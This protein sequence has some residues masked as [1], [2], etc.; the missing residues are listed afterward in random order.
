MCED[1]RAIAHLDETGVYVWNR[2]LDGSAPRQLTRFTDRTISAMTWSADG[3]R[4]EVT[5]GATTNDIVLFSGLK[6][7]TP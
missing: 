5:R 2:P 7:G 6:G 4:L 1:G 3:G